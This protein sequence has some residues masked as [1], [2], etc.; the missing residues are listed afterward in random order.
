VFLSEQRLYT[1]QQVERHEAGGDPEVDGSSEEARGGFKG[2]PRCDFCARRF[3]GDNE[4]FHHMSTEHYTCHICQRNNPGKYEYFRSYDHLENHFRAD[5]HVCED[6]ECL[7]K[8][9]VVFASEIELKHHI[10]QQHAGNM[11]RA[12][13]NRALQ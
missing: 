6:R 8:K 10:A 4:L 2:H 5:H 11:K 7:E 1:R 12:E 3:Y 9:F 13:R